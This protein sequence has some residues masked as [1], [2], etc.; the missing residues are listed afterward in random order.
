METQHIHIKDGKKEFFIQPNDILFVK[1]DGNYC[2]IYLTTQTVYNT[3][4]IQIGQL[5]SM[6]EELKP[7]LENVQRVGRSH[8]I[9][10]SYLQYA[11]PQTRTITLFKDKEVVLDNVSRDGI[12]ALLQMLSQKRRKEVL[13]PY[14]V[15][16]QLS[17]PVDE[18]NDER[19]TENGHEYVDLGLP[20]G[21]LWSTRSM[22]G[23]CINRLY[24]GWGELYPSDSYSMK[25]YIHKDSKLEGVLRMRSTDDVAHVNWGGNWRMPTEEEFSELAEV[26]ILQWCRT[27][28]G[29]TGC[30]CTGPNGNRIFLEAGGYRKDALQKPQNLKQ[31]AYFWTADA[32]ESGVYGSKAHAYVFSEY[33]G[34]VIG[35]S[36]LEDCCLGLTVRP[37]MSS[38]SDIQVENSKKTLL[39]LDDFEDLLA[40][41]DFKEYDALPNWR[42][43][44]PLLPREPQEALRVLQKW[45]NKYKP[46]A[47][48]GY[49]RAAIY[50]HQ[51]PAKNI[52]LFNPVFN[53]AEELD[54][55]REYYEDDETSL[56]EL[57]MRIKSFAALAEHQFDQTVEKKDCCW[58]FF[59]DVFYD[60]NGA[61][62]DEHFD[63]IKSFEMPVLQRNSYFSCFYAPLVAII[64][65]E[66]SKFQ[67][68]ASSFSSPYAHKIFYL[69]SWYEE[70]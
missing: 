16:M 20:S 43:V 69:S 9:N 44:S 19:L 13:V 11:D 42:I 53:P 32:S 47:I 30:L 23:N 27:K 29:K 68:R 17:V 40:S 22:G 51:L 12:K 48:I 61:I 65:S 26:C 37:V 64:D 1:A 41:W 35:Y 15:Q 39:E 33:D 24:Y 4:R 55:E 7:T 50:A 18:L 58:A 70:D 66:G 38:T 28:Y 54:L 60:K 10:L 14:L 59:K 5:W 46:D 57:E 63:Y 34:E 31:D 36:K 3:V 62:F 2:D 67:G 56:A 49:G 6:L 52:L 8:I 21:T 45:C 25:E